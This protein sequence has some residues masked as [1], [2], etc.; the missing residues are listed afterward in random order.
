[1]IEVHTSSS[2]EGAYI[3]HTYI[4]MQSTLLWSCH[5]PDVAADEFVHCKAYM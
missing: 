1:M 4:V 5:Q 3:V 2:G